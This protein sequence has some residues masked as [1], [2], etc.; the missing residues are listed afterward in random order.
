MVTQVTNTNSGTSV[1]SSK[2]TS[3]NPQEFLKIMIKEMQQQ[4]P[5]EPVSSKDLVNQLAQIRDIQSSMELSQTL[6]DLAISQKL[7]SAGILLGKEIFGKNSSGDDV[8]GIVTSVRREG[9]KVYLEL[10]TGERL[11]IDDVLAV[12]NETSKTA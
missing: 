11:S 4:D 12:N 8:T 9:D 7:S 1:G 10:D 5:M 3:I 6:K 2:M